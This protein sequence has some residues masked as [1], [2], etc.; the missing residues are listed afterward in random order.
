MSGAAQKSNAITM[1]RPY[2]DMP[3]LAGGIGALV[4]LLVLCGNID[5]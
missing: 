4:P 1:G 3:T 5:S 2:G